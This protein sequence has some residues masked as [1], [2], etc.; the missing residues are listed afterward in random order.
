VLEV[1]LGQVR[2]LIRQRD[3]EAAEALLLLLATGYGPSAEIFHA[4]AELLSVSGRLD[5]AIA[6]MNEAVQL[7]SG[8]ALYW[9]MRGQCLL[10][11]GRT[12]DAIPDLT[13]AIALAPGGDIAE[14]AYL[15]RAEIFTRIGRFEQ[16]EDDC[17]HI[18]DASGDISIGTLVRSKNEIL[19]ECRRRHGHV[20]RAEL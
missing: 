2:E 13:R 10:K 16:A 12:L 14:T 19:E 9:F 11:A 6:A 3:Y 15:F 8:D 5:E 4:R 7:D 20:R 17:E 1:R 18:P